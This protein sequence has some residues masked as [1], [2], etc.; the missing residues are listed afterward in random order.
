MLKAPEVW[1]YKNGFLQTTKGF[2]IMKTNYTK[3]IQNMIDGINDMLADY[4]ISINLK[5][6]YNEQTK[7]LKDYST[8]YLID[9]SNKNKPEVIARACTGNNKFN[10]ERI[11]IFNRMIELFHKN[12]ISLAIS[13]KTIKTIFENC[14]Y[15]F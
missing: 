6:E 10:F 9:Y 4:Y 11:A 13:K 8:M 3:N 2:L 12:K 14:F 15:K 7:E 5:V 1:S